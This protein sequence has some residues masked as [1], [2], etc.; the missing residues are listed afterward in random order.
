MIRDLTT[1]HLTNT[2]PTA[3]SRSPELRKD[4]WRALCWLPAL[5]IVYF[6]A[7]SGLQAWLKPAAKLTGGQLWHLPALLALAGLAFLIVRLA[8]ERLA[9]RSLWQ[10]AGIALGGGLV[11]TLALPLGWNVLALLT[12]L[13]GA[14]AWG[15]APRRDWPRLLFGR[16]PRT[17]ALMGF[18]IAVL[19]KI[20]QNDWRQIETDFLKAL[21]ELREIDNEL[22]TSRGQR[23]HWR[24]F[25]GSLAQHFAP[26]FGVSQN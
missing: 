25:L 20:G 21:A 13:A 4:A 18:S 7:L 9:T 22:A 16:S 11:L 6:W 24:D 3:F 26:L 15:A 23:A 14:L 5:A 8:P 1:Q 10:S 19:E 12:V 2:P 17:E